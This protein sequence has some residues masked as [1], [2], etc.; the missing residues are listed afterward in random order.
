MANWPSG[1]VQGRR[2]QVGGVWKPVRVAKAL[3][4]AWRA[5]VEAGG[6]EAMRKEEGRARQAEETR[7]AAM[8]VGDLLRRGQDVPKLLADMGCSRRTLRAAP[9][10]RLRVLLNAQT[11]AGVAADARGRWAVREITAWRGGYADREA[12]VVWDGF[13]PVSGVP[14]PAEWVRRDRLSK[15]LRSGGLIRPKRAVLEVQ[16]AVLG[17][18]RT[19]RLAGEAPGPMMQSE[20]AIR[21]EVRRS[22]SAAEADDARRRAEAEFEEAADGKRRSRRRIGLVAA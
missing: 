19:S 3:Q 5:W 14:W 21:K 6:V 7:A 15:D 2:R 4:H 18:K 12:W 8:M 16:A 11:A 17:G 1:G 20:A 13:D 22:R 10:V 9:G